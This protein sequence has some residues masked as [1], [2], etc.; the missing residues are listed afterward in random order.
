M[1]VLSIFIFLVISHC[2][3]KES[4]K[5]FLGHIFSCKPP[6]NLADDPSW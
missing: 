4:F 5:Y 6:A 2:I 1:V 3:D